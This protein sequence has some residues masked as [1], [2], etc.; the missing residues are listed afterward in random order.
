MPDFRQQGSKRR[1]R[2]VQQEAV[3][4]VLDDDNAVAP[5]DGGDGATAFLRH[6]DGRRVVQR[7]QGVQQLRPVLAAGGVEGI[8]HQSLVI[9]GEPD[10]A[11]AE[12][13]RGGEQSRPG[14]LLMQH[15]VAGPA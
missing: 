8:R 5:G 2:R 1:R 12:S 7:R 13:C 14:Q 10:R 11:H 6:D 3:D 9:D 15:D 4:V